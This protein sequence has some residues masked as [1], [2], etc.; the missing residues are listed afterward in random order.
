MNSLAVGDGWLECEYCHSVSI[1]LAVKRCNMC[2]KE[3]S[4]HSNCPLPCGCE[5][6]S[7]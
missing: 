4:V 1:A 6:T 5:H 3:W 2:G 7:E